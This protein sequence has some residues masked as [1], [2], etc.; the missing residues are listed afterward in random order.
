ME[1]YLSPP[2]KNKT[3]S[4]KDFS[5]QEE[6]KI[7]H[8]FKTELCNK[9]SI[10]DYCKYEDKCRFAHGKHELVDK[11]HFHPRYRQTSCLSFFITGYCSYG[12][13]CSFRHSNVRF[14][15]I[16][17][18]WYTYSLMT[19]GECSRLDVFKNLPK[20]R[21]TKLTK[22]DNMRYLSSL[23]NVLKIL[24]DRADTH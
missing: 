20:K 18:S 3:Q 14:Q 15:D 12:S 16:N 21:V 24:M 5:S 4:L 11:S 8:K 13:R 2:A 9:Y 22:L 7:D 6:S 1:V 17:R 19:G 10:Y 23:C